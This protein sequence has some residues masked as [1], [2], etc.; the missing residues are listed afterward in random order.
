MSRFSKWTT[1][2]AALAVGLALGGSQARAVD[3]TETLTITV[4]AQSATETYDFTT[5]TITAGPTLSA[6]VSGTFTPTTFLGVST[7]NFNNGSFDGGLVQFNVNATSTNSPGGN[8]SFLSIS[9]SQIV[10][11][12]GPQTV[13]IFGGATGYTMPVPSATFSDSTSG[14]VQTG[15]VSNV[16]FTASTNPNPPSPFN[17]FG[18]ATNTAPVINSGAVS[19]PNSVGANGGSNAAT[20]LTNPYAMTATLAVALNTSSST[21]GVT[22]TAQL[23]AVPEPSTIAAALTG[24]GLVGL[25]SLRRKLRN[26]A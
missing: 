12:D 19:A 23:S 21:S 26:R 2:L 4:G 14:T 8:T 17:V 1:A 5:A 13:S 18:A 3:V 15:S 11:S 9:T 25:T 10:N 22:G 16:R 24:L 6:G 7:L 20:G